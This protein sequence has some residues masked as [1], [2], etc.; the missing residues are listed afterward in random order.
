[1]NIKDDKK[2]A[3]SHVQA[4]NMIFN[5]TGDLYKQPVVPFPEEIDYDTYCDLSKLAYSNRILYYVAV[6]ILETHRFYKTRII[7]NA[8][9]LKKLGDRQLLKLHRTVKLVDNALNDDYLLFKTYK[10]YPYV[11]HDIDLIVPDVARARRLLG[12]KGFNLQTSAPSAPSI[13]YK[14][15]LLIVELAETVH[16]GSIHVVDKEILWRK[17]RKIMMC[18]V[19]TRIPNVEADVLSILAHMNFHLYGVMLGDLLY[20]FKLSAQADWNSMAEQAA[21]HKWLRSFMNTITVL[22]GFHRNFYGEPSPIEKYFPFLPPRASFELPH[23]FSLSEVTRALAE[24]GLF[25]LAKLPSWYCERLRK[26]SLGLA[27]A[28]VRVVIDRIGGFFVKYVYW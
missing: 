27:E 12:A 21:K 15:G 5:L 28:Y 26:K 4:M 16:W 18:D 13:F 14:K 6:K 3:S 7:K 8:K 11:T 24:H 20:V 19:E 22:N 2:P 1:M 9:L 23:I 17:P 10:S 25:N